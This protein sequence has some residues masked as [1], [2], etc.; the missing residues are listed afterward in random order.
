MSSTTEE[1]CIDCG[2]KFN[3]SLMHW[4]HNSY[5]NKKFSLNEYG[6]VCQICWDNRGKKALH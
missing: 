5:S 6:Y 4:G 3:T 2:H 1:P